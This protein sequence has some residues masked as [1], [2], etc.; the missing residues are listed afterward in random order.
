MPPSPIT[1]TSVYRP[2]MTVP[3]PSPVGDPG[4]ARRGGLRFRVPWWRRDRVGSNVSVGPSGRYAPVAI[5]V[6]FGASGLERVGGGRSAR[7][8]DGPGIAGDERTGGV[9]RG[10]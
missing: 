4:R 7:E 8:I 2:A 1:S 6:G 3:I 10:G 9:R 5:S